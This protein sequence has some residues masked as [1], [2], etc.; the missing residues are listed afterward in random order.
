LRAVPRFVIGGGRPVW[1]M[2]VSNTT[3]GCAVSQTRRRG[4]LIPYARAGGHALLQLHARRT[5]ERCVQL[6]PWLGWSSEAL[7]IAKPVTSTSDASAGSSKA[8]LLDGLGCRPARECRRIRSNGGSVPLLVCLVAAAVFLRDR[9]CGS[10]LGA[11]RWPR[12]EFVELPPG[13]RTSR[14]IQCEERQGA[15][16]LMRASEVQLLAM[17]PDWPNDNTHSPRPSRRSAL[18]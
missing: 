11:N 16:W 18:P 2:G 7:R 13:T 15:A 3:A 1:A 12:G 4:F 9:W 5:P 6:S 14:G 17:E 10:E 8:L